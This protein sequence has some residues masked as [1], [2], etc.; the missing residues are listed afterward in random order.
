MKLENSVQFIR[1]TT[2]EDLI[3]EVTEIQKDDFTYYVLNNPM[4]VVYMTGRKPGILSISLMQ[5]VFWRITD[6]Q[7]FYLS[8]K[9]I[10]TICNTSSSMEEY[11]WSSVEHVESFKEDVEMKSEDVYDEAEDLTESLESI[12]E[13]INNSTDKRKLH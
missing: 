13:A 8:P 10:L 1:L 2:G 11:Y 6:D 5:W 9:D 4:K 3:S 7:E 12:L